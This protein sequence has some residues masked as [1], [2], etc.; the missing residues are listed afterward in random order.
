VA[1]AVGL[2]GLGAHRLRLRRLSAG[3]H[4]VQEERARIARDLHDGL[5][6]GFTAIGFHVD[7]LR[8]HLREAPPAVQSL[9]DR[10]RQLV[11][12]CER[13][14]R[15]TIWRLRKAGPPSESLEEGLRALA[16]AASPRR[17]PVVRV[18]VDG[19][20]P[21][22]DGFVEAELLAIATEAVTNARRHADASRID[23]HL[24]WAPDEVTLTVRDDG[25]GIEDVDPD[26]LSA[27]GH[28]GLLGIHERVRRLRGRCR[29]GR[30]DGGGAEIHVQVPL[31]PTPANA[32]GE[33]S[34]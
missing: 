31:S 32:A 16:R 6:Q 23:L 12:L 3:F 13:E 30:A 9:I 1:V 18:T 2:A 7:A 10:T 8:E 21:R 24:G 25:R 17:R 11:D 34:P 14:A 27:D 26:A 29:I 4:L 28:F 20:P 5:G 33:M 19:A 22:R 15:G